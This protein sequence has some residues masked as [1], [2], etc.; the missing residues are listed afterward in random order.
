MW[1]SKKYKQKNCEPRTPA[2]MSTAA[3][4]G[5][6]D[7]IDDYT[8]PDMAQAPSKALAAAQDQEHARVTLWR[9]VNSLLHMFK[10]RGYDVTFVGGHNTRQ[11]DPYISA[12][13][14]E[15]AERAAIAESEHEIIIEAEVIDPKP[16]TTAWSRK[17]P[18]GSQLQ[19]IIITKGNVGVM[20][21]VL[22]NVEDNNTRHVILISRFP[23]TPYSKKW[24]SECKGIVVEF[25]LLASLQGIIERHKLVPKHIPLDESHAARVR[26]RYKD[27]RFPKLL[28]HDPMVQYL[29]LVPGMMV[30]INERMGREQATVSFFEVSEM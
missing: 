19:V 7:D 2:L 25:F 12:K 28:T 9:A 3:G 4:G 15:G 8:A 27:A 10:I 26:A 29:G 17:L 5:H 11:K 14:F 24:I 20:R 18:I 13:E 23:L 30:A 21:E 6:A 1:L 16:F 22:K